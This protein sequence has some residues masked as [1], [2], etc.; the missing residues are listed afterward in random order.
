MKGRNSTVV[1]IRVRD[2]DYEIVARLAS[3]KELTVSAFLKEKLEEMVRKA[4]N[5]ITNED[6]SVN[7]FSDGEETVNTTNKTAHSVNKNKAVNTM[8]S[9]NTTKV[10]GGVRY[11]VS[12]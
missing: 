12:S 9:V 10:I 2:E 3:K 8:G 1:S 7:H 11:K 6:H 5:T 4:V